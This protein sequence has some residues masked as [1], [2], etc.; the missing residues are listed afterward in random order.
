MITRDQIYGKEAADLLRAV[1]MYR[2]L[3]EEQIYRLYPGKEHVVKNL[4]THLVK[5]GRIY[6]NPQDRRYSA[7][8]DCDS[9]LDRGMLSA[10]WVLLDFIDQTEYHS[11]SDF[12]VKI[13]FFAGGEMYEIIHVPYEQEIL[14]NHALAEK[15][16]KNEDPARRIVLV[17]RPEQINSIKIPNVTGFCDVA[18]DGSVRYFKLE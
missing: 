4:L 15:T 13:C 5:Q 6:H 9:K 18:A 16:A 2:S 10:V 12:P 14:M 17:D 3:Q 1:T 11:V 7:D 8:R